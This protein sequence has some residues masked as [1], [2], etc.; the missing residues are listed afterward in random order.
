MG[1]KGKQGRLRLGGGSRG[2]TPPPD[3]AS[4]GGVEQILGEEIE[5]S[6]APTS[7][8]MHIFQRK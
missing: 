3:I 6:Y 2:A 8:V 1:G 4:G 5:K 7:E